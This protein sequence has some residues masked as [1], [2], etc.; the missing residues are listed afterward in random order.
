MLHFG[1]GPI[2]AAPAVITLPEPLPVVGL[3]TRLSTKTVYKEIPALLK[4]YA[5]YKKQN[6][7]PD[8]R[9]PWAFI[10]LSEHF[11]PKTLS[12]DYTVGD[13][14]TGHAHTP[15][16]LTA[17]QAPAGTYVVFRV[18]PRFLFLQGWAIAKT[19]KYAIEEWFP[20][21]PYAPTG[22][23]FEYNDPEIPGPLGLDIYFAASKKD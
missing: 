21:S 4:R 23:D 5:A 2:G 15:P 14:V 12:W 17:F 11:D 22:I 19:K 3:S 6:I 16:G 18:R 20:R 13:A 7:I 9:H 1:L 10:A 8:L